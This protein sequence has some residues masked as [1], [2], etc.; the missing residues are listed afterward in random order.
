MH[1]AYIRV[2]WRTPDGPPGATYGR[3]AAAR[4]RLS[5]AAVAPCAPTARVDSVCKVAVAGQRRRHA[6]ERASEALR[7]IGPPAPRGWAGRIHGLSKL[8]LRIGTDPGW[9]TELRT[10]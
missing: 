4:A 7:S 2:A 9:G 3:L 6:A 1:I 10:T 5:V 8:D